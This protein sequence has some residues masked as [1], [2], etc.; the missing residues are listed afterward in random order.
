MIVKSFVPRL[1]LTLAFL[2]GAINAA[3]QPALTT[4]SQILYKADG[5]PYRGS[6]FIS[7]PTFDTG[8]GQHVPAGTKQV[9]LSAT[10][11]L[12]VSLAPNVGAVPA[13]VSYTVTYKLDLGQSRTVAWIVP[14]SGPVTVTAIES[15][16]LV[17]P[18]SI[19]A[20]S[21]LGSGGSLNGQCPVWNTTSGTWVPTNCGAGAVTSVS[22]SGPSWLTW[23][24]TNPT[25]TP[26]ISLAPTT[27]QASHQV[28]GTC[29]GA[30]TF[31]P[32]ALVVADLPSTVVTAVTN[33]T[34]VTGSISGQNLTLGWTGTLAAVRM[35]NAGVHTGDCI[36]TFPN[37]TISGGAIGLS[38]MANLAANSTICNN[39]GSAATPIA[40]SIAQMQTLLS[41]PTGTGTGVFTGQAN[42]YS[43]GLQ[44]FGAAQLLAPLGTSNPATCAVGQVFFRS[45]SAAG[46]NWW[47]CTATNTWSQQTG[48]G[49]GSVFTGST[50]TNPTFSATPT[51]SLAD[52]S[53]KSPVRIETAVMTANVSP[54]FTNKT[55]GAKFSIV[56]TQD[57]T[58]GRTV[59]YGVSVMN[60]CTVDPTPG[61]TTTQ[62]FEVGADGSTVNGTGCSTTGPGSVPQ[63][64]FGT[65]PPG[66]VSGN[67]PGD[68]YS[69]TTNHNEYWCN[70]VAG[71]AAPACTAVAVGGW[72]LL[73]GGGTGGTAVAP[74]TTTVTS[75]TSVSITA[76]THGQ[77]T[78]A[79]PSCFD[80]ST[81]RVSVACGYT[82]NT[83]GDLVFAFSPA[84]TGQIEIGSGGGIS[85]S[86]YSSTVTAQTSVSITA[87][88][89]AHGT[90]P[91]AD[92]FNNSSPALVVSCSYTRNGS[93]DLVFT[94]SPAFTGTIEIRY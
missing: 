65:A 81:P 91:R 85:I 11:L 76:A 41:V 39:T 55:A 37:C 8:A 6:V 22:G 89:H 44:N 20:L 9:N 88:T 94:F 62:F 25:T 70:A 31:A 29:G 86:P 28:I 3:A 5:A 87:A 54:I 23:T 75:Q 60:A 66:S 16:T 14:A 13:G 80:N 4:V 18:S 61:A 56:W 15:T 17:G 12:S 92:C 51:F 90:T 33:D 78:L 52:I 74:Y 38:K 68:F 69:D 35:V 7:W 40:C 83:S 19:V 71:T 50:A 42:T 82:R 63:R 36:T 45:D 64:F 73:N 46:Q 58:G 27:G 43:T 10:G 79:T 77:G 24:I 1:L 84:F 48:G 57:G 53:V 47:F 72:T 34:N 21:Q 26:A 32:C 49:G 67:L 30:T 93:G 59:T 2:I